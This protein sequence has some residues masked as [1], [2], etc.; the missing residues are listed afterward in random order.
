MDPVRIGIVKFLNTVPLVEGLE[1]IPQ[2]GLVPAPPSQLSD[3]LVDRVADVALVSIIDAALAREPLAMLS[4]GMIGCDGPTLTVRVFS[5]V[6]FE[7]ITTLHADSESHTSI[8]LARIVLHRLFDKRVTI[9]PFE[10]SGQRRAPGEWPEALLLIGD[11]VITACPPMNRF[12]HQ[13]DLGEQWKKLTDLPF[14]YAVWMCRVSDLQEP[15]RLA[16]IRLAESLLDR[17]L[18]HNMTRVD[19]IIQDRSEEFHWP[20]E[21]AREY[22]GNLLRYRLGD[23]ERSA[24]GRFFEEAVGAGILSAEQ[25]SRVRWV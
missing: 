24:V 18:R 17:Q 22:I 1:K 13:L 20:P 14:V 3:M 16:N 19:R 7:Q 10:S 4:C 2:V 15:S 11:K 9:E 5:S 23:A 12:P 21:L 8:A 6:P 25:A